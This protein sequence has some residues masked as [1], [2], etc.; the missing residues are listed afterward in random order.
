[1][2]LAPLWPTHFRVGVCWALETLET[3]ETLEILEILE[4]LE[5]LETLAKRIARPLW[6]KRKNEEP[7]HL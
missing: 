7:K 5:T 2:T 6:E 4:T 1:M 3:L